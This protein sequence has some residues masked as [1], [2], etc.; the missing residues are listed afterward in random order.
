MKIWKKNSDQKIRAGFTLIELLV[1]I[2]I[3]GLL[4]TIVMVSLNSARVKARNAKR[5]SDARQLATAFNMAADAA[6]GT[7]PA[8]SADLWYCVSVDCYGVWDSYAASAEI[9]AAVAPYIKKPDDQLNATTG[10]G[11]YM[12]NGAWA[13]GTGYGGTIFPAG[14]YLTFALEPVT[15]S[16]GVCGSGGI[17][18][19]NESLVQ[20]LLKIN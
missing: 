6:G 10:Y 8:S 16:A 20:C 5:I 11:G 2:A 14:A 19:A 9:D 13:G 18:I 17:W 3:I 7:F 15:I 1:V 12:Y 4:A